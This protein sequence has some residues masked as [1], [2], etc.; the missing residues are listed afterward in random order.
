MVPARDL[1]RRHR[2]AAAPH[3]GHGEG[4]VD[5]VKQG[6]LIARRFLAVYMA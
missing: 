5:K 1:E 3:P 2:R 6:F 4:S